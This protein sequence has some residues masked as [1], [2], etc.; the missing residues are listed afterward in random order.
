MTSHLTCGV[1][2][3][4]D[5][6]WLW[7]LRPN[8][9]V[10]IFITGPDEAR[11]RQDHPV[12]F[13]KFKN[14]LV[15]VPSTFA[16]SYPDISPDF[17]W[18]S[19]SK[20]FLEH[21]SLGPHGS[22]VY[23]LSN[24]ARRPPSDMI[25]VQWVKMT[26]KSVGG[27]TNARG[28]FGIDYRSE[29]ISVERDLVRTLGHIIKFSIRPEVCEPVVGTPHYVMS[30]TLSVSYPRRPVVYPT[31]MSR[32][33]WGIRN[34]TDDE[35]RVSFDLPDFVEWEDRYLKDIVPL[36]LFRSV[37]ESVLEKPRPEPPRTRMKLT[38]DDTIFPASNQDVAW[39]ESIQRWLPG[40]WSDADISDKAVKSDNSPVD[41][42]PWHRRIQL[43]FPCETSTL[44]VFER[45]ATR[46]WR[47]N[48]VRSLFQFISATYGTHWRRNF[49]LEGKRT[50][51]DGFPRADKRARLKTS[52]S[53]STGGKVKG[54]RPLRWFILLVPRTC[55]WICQEDFA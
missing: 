18:I 19:G 43:V 53:P 45:L 49:F 44:E 10:N 39:L 21:V 51:A 14:K 24:S 11:L 7:S 20:C 5:P 55:G 52:V 13:E 29:P 12:L 1:L 22:H 54:G 50:L 6:V 9:W 46:K 26:H 40:T 34:L 3:E 37:I 8:S 25:Q 2:F 36:Q 47:R 30:D 41:F 38:E 23:W 17:I 42:K 16:G 33:G 28:T 35:L 27:V 48:V 15:T 4:A 31:Y 32:T